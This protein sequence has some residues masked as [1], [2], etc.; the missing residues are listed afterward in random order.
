MNKIAIPSL[1]I[2]TIMIAGAFAFIPVQEASTVHTTIATNISQ[3]DR[4]VT[5]NFAAGGAG[6]VTGDNA[7]VLPFKLNGY[8]AGDATVIVSDGVG[9][10]SVFEV[11]DGTTGADGT[12]AAGAT[13]TG[14]GASAVNAFPASMDRLEVRVASGVDCTVV[15]TLSET[16]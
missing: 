14:V 10:C 8:M 6:L 9:A 1:L 4:I 15:V 7:N 16:T 2:V 5:F 13:Q 12:E 3:Q 11:S